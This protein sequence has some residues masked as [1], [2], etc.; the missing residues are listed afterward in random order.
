MAAEADK[1]NTEIETTRSRWALAYAWL[2]GLIVYAV[3]IYLASN[4]VQV[5]INDL[6]W[7]LAAAAAA[8]CC[9]RAARHVEPERRRAWLWVT[10]AC[11]SWLL[12]QLHWN[13]VHLILKV[14][15]PFPSLNQIFY[16]GFAI[17][18]M[19]GVMQLPEARQREPFT[20]K[21][22]GNLGLVTCCLAV[23]VVLGMLE[24]ALQ[25]PTVTAAFLWLGIAHTVLVAGTFLFTLSALWTFR[26]GSAWTPMLLMVIGT[27]IYAV[28]NF[29]YAHSLLTDSYLPDDVVN[30]SWLLMF[31]LVAGAAHEQAWLSKR[32]QD[33]IKHKTQ[34]RERWLEAVM[35]ALLIVIMIAVALSS[36][37]TFTPRVIWLSATIFILFAV[38]LGAREAWIQRESQQLTDQLL[39]A[40]QQLQDANLE[41]RHSEQRFRELTTA[42]EHRVGERTT[43]L[44]RAYEELEGFSY[45]V[46][47]DLKAPLRAINGFAHLFEQEMQ[48][49]LTD[50][51]REHLSRIRNG[52]L[53]MS[54]LIDDLLSYSHIDRRGMQASV[55]SL[56]S[57]VDQVLSPYQDEIQ[58]RSI[59]MTV[60]VEPMTVRVDA[61]GLSQALRNLVENALKYT[62]DTKSPRIAVVCRR[63]EGG[64]LLAVT[65][66]GI[67]FDMQYH[68]HIFKLFQRLH[69]DDQYP[70]TGIGL[71]LVRKAIE[72]LGGK[73]WAQSK[74]NEGSTFTIE[75]PG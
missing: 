19:I 9:F 75:L 15:Q 8:Y 47:H 46:A 48:G 63:K 51:A 72:R 66:N 37:A 45:A 38:I 73:V 29:A 14:Q 64:V 31:G 32:E 53:K 12:G 33:D 55:V 26:W 17:F 10:A 34:V 42:L 61:S 25:N 57:L 23:T 58:R 52:S 56:P 39:S 30:A 49:E 36:S 44:K 11:A 7:T 4:D 54:T 68:D 60:V 65:D 43:E 22:A 3:A 13:Y 20:L 59:M 70:G 41:L 6:A 5:W 28:S 2:S 67:G 69:R 16:T 40:N 27:C 62:R 71:A 1:L 24:P 18:I 74:P 50:R 21:H 35:P